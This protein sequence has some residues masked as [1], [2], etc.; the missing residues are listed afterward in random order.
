MAHF[1]QAVSIDDL[2][3]KGL[4]MKKTLWI[5]SFITTLLLSS[6]SSAN[7]ITCLFTEPFFSTS[8]NTET[9]TLTIEALGKSPEVIHSVSLQN[10]SPEKSVLIDSKNQMLQELDLNFSGSDG[11]S[12]TVYPYDAKFIDPSNSSKKH[13]GGCTSDFL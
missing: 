9:Q 10:K 2:K 7:T 3:N 8:Y 1:S 13:F 12:D 6:I 4:I 11:M 5:T